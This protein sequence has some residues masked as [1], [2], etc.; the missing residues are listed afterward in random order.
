MTKSERFTAIRNHLY[1]TGY[2]SVQSIAA[3][4]GASLATVRRDLIELENAGS[5]IREHGG[6][7]IS[8][9]VGLEVAFEQREQ[10]NLDQKRAIANAAY[11]EI[12]PN[13]SVFLDAGT[14]VYQLA[15]RIRLNPFPINIFTNCVPI[16]QELLP[17][18]EV[19]L[20]LIG[21]RLRPENASMVGSIAERTLDD[22]R[23][24]QLFLGCG[25][26]ADDCCIYSADEAEANINAKMLTRATQKFLMAD[27]NK[28]GKNLTYRVAELSRDLEILSDL[29]LGADWCTKLSERNIVPRLVDVDSPTVAL[30]TANS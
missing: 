29:D 20:T 2:A 19:S 3:A 14:T 18:S 4:L 23:F 12:K 16:A 1:N 6:A 7:S 26:V 10:Q 27:S 13:I 9:R 5:I 28:F 24:D 11:N 17:V 15:R 25:S 30:Q 8:D 22:L 21:G